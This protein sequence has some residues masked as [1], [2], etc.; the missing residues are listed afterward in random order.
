MIATTARP[1]Q[2]LLALGLSDEDGEQE[3]L[4]VTPEHPFWVEGTGWT[5]AGDLIP[6]Q[7]IPSAHGGWL[8]VGSVLWPHRFA[9]VFNLEVEGVHTYFAGGL[10]AWVHNTCLN[11]TGPGFD[12]AREEAL[13]KAGLTDPSDV[14]FSKVDPETGTVVEFKG[15]GGAKVGYDGPHPNSPGP[16]HDQQYIRCS[17][18][19]SG[20]LAVPYEKTFHTAAHSTHPDQA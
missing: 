7:L 12:K 13:E 6:G 15:P 17:P 8:R 20:A 19:E 1:G 16:F 9:T 3:L 14:T 11:P 2:P 4:E 5:R 18:L 10:G